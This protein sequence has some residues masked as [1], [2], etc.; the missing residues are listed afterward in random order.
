M[1]VTSQAHGSAS[2]WQLSEGSNLMLNMHVCHS[3]VLS[4]LASRTVLRFSDLCNSQAKRVSHGLRDLLDLKALNTASFQRSSFSTAEKLLINS[5][6]LW[7]VHL[8]VS[9]KILVRS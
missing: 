4:F 5:F 7:L 9:V 1:A 3:A 6:Q 8:L 2:S